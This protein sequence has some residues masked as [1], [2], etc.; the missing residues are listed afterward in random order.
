MLTKKRISM[1][2]SAFFSLV[3]VIGLN[4]AS[5]QDGTVVDVIAESEDHTILAQMLEDTEL[6]N[7]I[8]QQGPFT[9]IAPTDEAF[10]EMG[11]ELEQ[12]QSSPEQMQ[13]LVIGHLFQ[14][15]VPAED[16]EPT[17]NIEVKEGDIPA[18]NGTVHVVEE[19]IQN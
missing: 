6:G 11:P 10:E 3:L 4:T 17:L 8:A 9:V 7:V 14:G 5:A 16:A 18:S 1:L 15:E 12:I 19:V 2:L 13:N